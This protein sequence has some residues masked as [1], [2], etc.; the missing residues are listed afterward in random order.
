M[1]KTGLADSPI[2]Q[3]STPKP[4]FDAETPPIAQDDTVIPRHHDTTTPWLHDTMAR[5]RRAVKELGKEAATHRFT[6]QEKA[7]VGE[8]VFTYRQ[9]GIRTSE[10][11]VTRIALNYL[12]EDYRAQGEQSILSQILKALH[13]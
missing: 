9:R 8:I 5:I 3:S 13:Q 4:V 11:E 1:K 6:P 7:A 10:N 2:F 12:V